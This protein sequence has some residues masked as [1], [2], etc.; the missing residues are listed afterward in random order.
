[1][2]GSNA[3]PPGLTRLRYAQRDAAKV[4]D[5]LV[6]LAGVESGEV[7]VLFDDLST[8]GVRSAN[9][10]VVLALGSGVAADREADRAFVFVVPDAVFLLEAEPEVRVLVVDRRATVGLVRRSVGVEDLGHD[11][12]AVL[13]ARVRVAGDRLEQTVGGAPFGLLRRGTVERPHR[14]VFEVAREV[15]D[16]LRLASQALGRLVTIK[17]DVFELG[18]GTHFG[19]TSIFSIG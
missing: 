15:L 11:Q 16:D 7:E 19:G 8:D 12:E 4:R 14:A 5:V 17:P 13:A 18:L 9:R 6:E 10:A 2:V 1:M 3:A